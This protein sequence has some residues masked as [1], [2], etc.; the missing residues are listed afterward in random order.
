VTAMVTM[1]RPMN[2]WLPRR[3]S[4]TARFFSTPNQPYVTGRWLG[5][6]Y[7]GTLAGW[8]EPDDASF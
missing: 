1:G 4:A 7:L 2:W 8:P 5:I 6:A 3:A